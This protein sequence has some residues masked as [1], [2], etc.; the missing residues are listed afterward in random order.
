MSPRS[1]LSQIARRTFRWEMSRAGAVGV[2]ESFYWTFA[3]LVLLRHF[4]SGPT[5]KALLLSAH[6]AG[7][8]ASLFIAPL[9]HRFG[10][11][12]PAFAAGIS[13]AGAVGFFGAAFC[14]HSLWGFV[15]LS[16]FGL[17]CQ[18]LQI[19]LHTRIYRANYPEKER[20]RLFSLTLILRVAAM[21]AFAA[22]AGQWLEADI[23]SIRW[24]LWL[25]GACG[26]VNA[27]CFLR[28]PRPIQPPAARPPL[29]AALRHL[30]T[31]QRFRRLQVSWMFIGLGNL[32]GLAFFV[33]YLGSAQ[34]GLGLSTAVVALLTGVLPQVVQVSTSYGW[35]SLFDRLPFYQVRIA[36]N[37]VFFLSIALFYFSP[38]LLGVAAGIALHGA[39]RGGGGILWNLWA[40]KLADEDKVMDF[41]SA[42]TF[43][44]GL[45]ALAAP[46]LAFYLS[47]ATSP[48]VTA[49]VCLLLMLASSMVIWPDF[50]EERRGRPSAL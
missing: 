38:W 13:L 25:Y 37:T 22:L 3:V 46:F 47:A 11:S 8:L 44:A 14:L 15:L 43:L 40:T 9:R 48:Q 39:G 36:I 5:S 29:F 12:A 4:E 41:M 6:S 7:L 17:F 28:I 26:L 50:L 2:L 10:V 49:M 45:R 31:D 42:H 34:A 32:A 20:G 1:P 24:V 21:S 33:E 16:G 27:A 30:K 19:P 18:T 23:R 35:G